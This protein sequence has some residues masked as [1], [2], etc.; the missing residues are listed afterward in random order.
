MNVMNGKMFIV[1][2]KKATMPNIKDYE[3]ILVGADIHPEIKE[4][5]TV[6]NRGINISRK[7]PNYCELTGIYWI[8]K[9]MHSDFVG[10]SH[11]RRYFT[12][13]LISSSPKHFLT[14]DKAGSVLQNKRIILPKVRYSPT[15][16]ICAINRAPNMDDVKEMYQAIGAC[17]PQYID[18]YIWYLRQNKAHLYNMFVMRWDDFSEYCDWI[19]TLLDYIEERHDMNAETDSYRLRLYGFLSERLISVWVHHNMDDTEIEYYPVVNTEENK[20]NRIKHIVANYRRM[21]QFRFG[22]HS[23]INKDYE[24]SIIETIIG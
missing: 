6:D 20:I 16:I 22:K 8:W 12:K 10:I 15:S 13:S 2:H 9:N 14:M 19:F 1:T 18:D 3:P 11:Y 17:F 21:L 5:E 4:Y 24:D 23:S 7:N